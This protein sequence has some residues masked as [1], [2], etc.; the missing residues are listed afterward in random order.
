MAIDRK[1][2][3][4]LPPFMQKYRELT[5]L[6]DAEQP[7]VDRLWTAVENALADQF[8]MDATED[9]I[10]R[11]ERVLGIF[12]KGTDTLDERK[13]RVIAMLNK[14]LPYT[15]RSFEQILTNLCGADGY[16][17]DVNAAEYKI[18]IKLAVANKSNY[19]EVEK[20]LNTMIPANMVKLIS[21]MYTRHD[22]L[23]Q[24]THEYL[25]AFT[26]EHIRSEVLQ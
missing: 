14:E 9:G 12:P 17:I 22:V 26:H 11:W 5:V 3:D 7:E 16:S 2:I 23:S 4:Y 1:L 6:M 15:L 8:V 10:K 21:I 20:L 13:F 19:G 24:Y 25:S 18:E